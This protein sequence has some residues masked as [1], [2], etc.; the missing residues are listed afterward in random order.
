M[1]IREK[2]DTL[3][4]KFKYRKNIKSPSVILGSKDIKIGRKTIIG[5]FSVLKAKKE[6]TQG[7]IVVGNSVYIGENAYLLAGNG[8]VHIGNDVYTGN[9]LVLLGGGNISIGNNVLMSHNIV[10]SSSSHDLKDKKIMANKTPAIFKATTILDNVFIGANVTILMGST[11]KQGAV[12]GAGSIVTENTMID[13]YEVW[14]GNPAKRVYTRVSLKEQVEE[15]ILH[16]LKTYP[17]HNLFFLHEL[18]EVEA[19]NY[20]GTCSD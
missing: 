14:V 7:T 17:F 5:Q 10:I 1:S 15:K 3:L 16:Y 13:E 2:I 19:S 20:G 9:N 4:F 12:I 18:K 8:N 11:I 6:N